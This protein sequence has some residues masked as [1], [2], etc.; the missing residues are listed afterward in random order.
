[1]GNEI[2]DESLFFFEKLSEEHAPFLSSFQNREKDLADFLVDDALNNQKIFLSTTFVVFMGSTDR[3]LIGYITLLADSVRLKESKELENRFRKKG[4]Q[5][6]YLPA[7][8]IGRMA[9]DENHQRK[10]IGKTMI[11]FAIAMV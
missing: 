5:Y 4:V 3:K 2:I 10:G 6:S 1:M 9:V 8:K 11:K 7:M